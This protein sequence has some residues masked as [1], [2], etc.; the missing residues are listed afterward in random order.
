MLLLQRIPAEV[1]IGVVV[2]V[3]VSVR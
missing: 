3:V 2:D 1:G